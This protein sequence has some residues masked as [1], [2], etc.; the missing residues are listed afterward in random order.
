MYVRYPPTPHYWSGSNT[1]LRDSCPKSGFAL[2]SVV[3]SPSQKTKSIEWTD[4]AL[5]MANL[6]SHVER[7][8]VVVIGGMREK[9][10]RPVAL[11]AFVN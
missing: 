4:P 10:G 7:D 11:D 9:S 3:S 1:D 8:V 2:A 5:D 6:R